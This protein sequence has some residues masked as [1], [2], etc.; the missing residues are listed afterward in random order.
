MDKIS[1]TTRFP[2]PVHR[3]LSSYA[4]SAGVSL[5]QLVMVACRDYLLSRSLESRDAKIK[6][7]DDVVMSLRLELMELRR[8]APPAHMDLDEDEEEVEPV[9]RPRKP[10][11][12]RNRR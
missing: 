10:K 9:S 7:L 1:V 11:P 4:A 5:N 12:R 2:E 6:E 3:A 8:A